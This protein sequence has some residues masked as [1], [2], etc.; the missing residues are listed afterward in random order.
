M[1]ILGF[2]SSL[3][4]IFAIA[5][6]M[7]MG[8]MMLTQKTKTSYLGYMKVSR[9]I[10]NQMETYRYAK[11]K[12]PE[13]EK[14]DPASPH[15]PE[16]QIMKD[17]ISDE[18]KQID[19]IQKQ[20]DSDPKKRY[21]PQEHSPACSRLNLYPLLKKKPDEIVESLHILERLIE[22]LYGKVL[23]DPFK[24]KN[25]SK[26]LALAIFQAAKE[27]IYEEENPDLQ[28]LEK[29]V[30]PHDMQY[31]YY[32]M[33]KGSSHYSW[34]KHE[35]FPSLLDY[36]KL[37]KE[38]SSKICLNCAPFETLLSLF[39]PKVALEL[40]QKREKTENTLTSMD[41]E[42]IV[43][44]DPQHLPKEKLFKIVKISCKGKKEKLA[45]FTSEE[46]SAKIT[47]RKRVVLP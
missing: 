26:K 5:S 21:K 12:R 20:L 8:K 25:F 46:E 16:V 35:G 9:D 18:M 45:T 15:S 1:N 38:N 37:Q 22:N 10:Q 36:V 6:Q 14:K 30:L 39:S 24:D 47:L 41:I 17:E 19:D 27:Q 44:R 11:A 33:L 34:E 29:L 32:L 7:M 2:V 13:K 28:K 3:L 40:Y 42:S 4:L 43:F 23:F 31:T